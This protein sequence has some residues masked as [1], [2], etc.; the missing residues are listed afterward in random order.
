MCGLGGQCRPSLYPVLE[1]TNSQDSQETVSD[2]E[3]IISHMWMSQSLHGQQNGYQDYQKV[4]EAMEA[5]SKSQTLM[6]SL[7]SL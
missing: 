6:L 7:I 3:T 2:W 1:I 5:T 4:M